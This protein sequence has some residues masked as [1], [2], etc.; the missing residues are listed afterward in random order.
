LALSVSRLARLLETHQYRQCLEEASA[1][2]AAGGHDTEAEARIHAAICRSCLELGAYRVAAQAG[3]CAVTLARGA[4]APDLT[5]FA[6]ADLASAQARERRYEDALQT[7]NAYLAMLPELVAARCREGM[8]R[9]RMGEAFRRIGEPV[10]AASAY[11][12]A[13]TWFDRFGD[14]PGAQDCIRA[15]VS[16]RLEQGD[17]AAARELLLHEPPGRRDHLLDWARYYLAA[18]RPQLAA[19]QAFLALNQAGESLDLQCQ[20]QMLLCQ[21]ALDQAKAPEALAFALAARVSAMEGQLY[22]LEF[23]AAAVICRLL[24]EHGSELLHE[25]ARDFD[26]QG[27]DIYQYLGDPGLRRCLT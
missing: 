11:E 16:L 25:V 6:L 5:G 23:E 9:F 27:V 8:V 18:A 20:A 12:A 24:K 21:S 10:Q 3:D 26:E 14:E 13:R 1:L 7:W 22:D 2:L 4:G 17:T 19:E 15:L